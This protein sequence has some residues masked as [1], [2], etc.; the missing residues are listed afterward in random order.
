MLKENEYI[1]FLIVTGTPT[2]VTSMRTGLYT[3]QL[4][5]SAP[6]SDTPPV[7]GYEV[8]YT[9]SGSGNTQSGGN[10]TD[11]TTVNVT[12]PTLGLTYKFFVVAFSD[13]E[14]SLPSAR[15]NVITIEL[16]ESNSFKHFILG[17]YMYLKSIVEICCLKL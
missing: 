16:S 4:S 17:S 5:W 14:N 12:L 1:C 6:D 7:E 9:G 3:V 2:N 10:T 13:A 8:F 11:N 15:S